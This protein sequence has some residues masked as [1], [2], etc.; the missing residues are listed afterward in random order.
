MI[1]WIWNNRTRWNMNC[2]SLSCEFCDF[3]CCTLE[4]FIANSYSEQKPNKACTH[5][6]TEQVYKTTYCSEQRHLVRYLALSSTIKKYVYSH[7]T[8]QGYEQLIANSSPCSLWLEYLLRTV[9][10]EYISFFILTNCSCSL[11]R[12]L[13]LSI[14]GQ[15]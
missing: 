12:T 3:N 1:I 8:E 11:W 9:R 13:M 4:F 2:I 15:L 14:K 10:K 5:T 7:S 6:S